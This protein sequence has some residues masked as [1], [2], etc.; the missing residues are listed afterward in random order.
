MA[1]HTSFLK[2]L[3]LFL[4]ITY[5][6]SQNNS[7]STFFTNL[8][9]ITV[10]SLYSNSSSYLIKYRTNLDKMSCF[11]ECSLLTECFLLV[12]KNQTCLLYNEYSKFR[13]VS[14][15]TSVSDVTYI[16]YSIKISVIFLRTV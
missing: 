2:T 7:Y 16:V 4:S 6:C 11:V 12:H 14:S 1:F 9:N 8:R 3:C 5:A 13:L 10:D 15:N